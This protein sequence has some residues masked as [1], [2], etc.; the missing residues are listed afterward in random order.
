[1]KK[2]LLFSIIIV[3]AL[4]IYSIV[5][6]KKTKSVPLQ[7]QIKNLENQNVKINNKIKILK[8]RI[9]SVLSVKHEKK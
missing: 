9:D 6:D 1:M 4:E 3:T 5:I 7:S 2:I 8:F